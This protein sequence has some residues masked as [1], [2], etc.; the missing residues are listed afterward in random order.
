MDVDRIQKINELALQLMKQGLVQERDEAVNQA[1]RMLSKNDYSDLRGAMGEIKPH[2]QEKPREEAELSQ[3]QI[4]NILKQNADFMVKKFKEYQEVMSSMKNEISDLKVEIDSLKVRLDNIKRAPVLKEA[5][6]KAEG[7]SDEKA[8]QNSSNNS[9]G[10]A[11]AS[12]SSNHPRSGNFVD[13][14]VSIEKFFYS[15]SKRQN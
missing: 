4:K 12:P 7:A 9:S 8:Q 6:R 3:D 2:L 13:T 10:T 5:V 1:E 14:D 11:P 15:G